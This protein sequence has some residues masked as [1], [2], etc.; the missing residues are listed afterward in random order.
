MTKTKA[1][2]HAFRLRTLPLALSSIIT[3]A[4]LA[5]FD[6]GFSWTVSILAVVTTILLQV[7]SNL[8][9][10]YGDSSHGVDN[11][12]RVGPERA[13]QS[14]V[15]SS[16]EMKKAVIL[17][18]ILAFISGVSLLIF[19]F[20][21][22]ILS[23]KFLV[24]LILVLPFQKCETIASYIMRGRIKQFSCVIIPLTWNWTT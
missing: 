18:S 12:N 4:F 17:F 7:L 8:A 9:N 2:I 13:V 24:F 15:I 1:W 3:G 21:K 23:I 19:G 6:G 14:G 10:D 22:A 20:G 5:Y 11:A 16:K